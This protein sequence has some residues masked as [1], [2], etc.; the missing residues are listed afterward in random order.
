MKHW[1]LRKGIPIEDLSSRK[2]GYQLIVFWKDSKSQHLRQAAEQEGARALATAEESNRFIDDEWPFPRALLD[3]HISELSKLHTAKTSYAL[4]YAAEP[5]A[6]VP[7]P[8]FLLDV[9]QPLKER[10]ARA[11]SRNDFEL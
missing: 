11:H 3:E 7:V 1:L 4:R 2:Y 10:L 8:L 6:K 9:F 5:N